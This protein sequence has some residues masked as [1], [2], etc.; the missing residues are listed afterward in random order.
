LITD[1]DVK[2]LA[3]LGLTER[4]AKIYLALLQNG[5]SNAETISK[6][7]MVHRQEI[8]KIAGYLQKIGLVEVE[9]NSPTLFSAVSPDEA[10]NELFGK[11]V[12]QL[13]DT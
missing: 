5:R 7:S 8:Y 1:E 9:V 11:K 12:K 3:F 13:N 10:L 4:Q 2:T 6:L